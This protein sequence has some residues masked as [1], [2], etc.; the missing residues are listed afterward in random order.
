MGS[1]H[2]YRVAGGDTY[3]ILQARQLERVAETKRENRVKAA[4]VLE[5]F[6][7]RHNWSREDITE[8]KEA[9]GLDCNEVT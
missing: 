6:G 4:E 5:N 9:L 2:G 1:V 8:V 3:S 7:K